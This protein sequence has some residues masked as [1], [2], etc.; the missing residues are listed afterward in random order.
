MP[1]RYYK[2]DLL[3]RFIR[4]G[5][6]LQAARIA[7]RMV[8]ALLSRQRQIVFSLDTDG[9]SR[10]PHIGVPSYSIE[11]LTCSD[12][13]RRVLYDPYP[14]LTK[15][16]PHDLGQ[17]CRQGA[18]F[19]IGYL[20]GQAACAGVSRTQ[21]LPNPY[22]V[23]IRPGWVLLSHFVTVPAYRGK[24][25]YPALLAHI[26]R[27]MAAAGAPGFLIDCAD[28]N[29]ASRRGIERAGFVPIGSGCILRT[30][31]FTFRPFGPAVVNRSVR[32]ADDP[33]RFAADPQAARE[34]AQSP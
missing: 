33:D 6:W 32:A 26:V 25:L 2:V 16:L 15:H 9:A 34:P 10:V 12:D 21:C 18:V 11:T 3:G 13:V 28:W 31:R 8:R 23:P 5:T 4:Q 7:G 29:V 14:E 17:Y 20:D 27:T 19:W 1:N 22:F 24:G 30:G